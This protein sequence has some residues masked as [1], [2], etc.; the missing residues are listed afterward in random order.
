MA[1]AINGSSNTITGIAVGGL[2]NGIVDTDMLADDSVTAPKIGS[3]T[4]TSYALIADQKAHDVDGGAF[5]AGAWRQRDLNTEISDPDGIVSITAD[6]D[7]TL[8]AGSY[9]VK[10]SAPAFRVG[11]HMIKLTNT[12]DSS[13]V[14]F[15]TSAYSTPAD[16][17]STKAL[18]I[19]R[20]TIAS[21]KDFGIFH[22]SETSKTINGFGVGADF[23]GYT[24]IY[25]IV[26]IYKEA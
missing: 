7:F 20:F 18:L 8:Q 19:S 10:A 22:R 4:F 24:E 23:T 2:P 17:D 12:T 13:D 6:S 16:G 9:L 15:G 25:T 21:A 5:T 26:E 11:R 1:I 14:Q 3:K